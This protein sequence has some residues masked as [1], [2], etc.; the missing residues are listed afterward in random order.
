MAL[1][2]GKLH[3]LGFHQTFLHHQ[4]LFVLMVLVL[5]LLVKDGKDPVRRC[6]GLL[7]I[8]V[9]V[10]NTLDGVCQIDGIN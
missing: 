10:G 5:F 4:R 3:V 9:A 2:I 8:A 6:Q 1:F 7:D